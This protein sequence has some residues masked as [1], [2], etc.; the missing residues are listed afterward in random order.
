M[1]INKVGTASFLFLL[2]ICCCVALAPTDGTEGYDAETVEETVHSISGVITGAPEDAFLITV[3]DKNDFKT[4]KKTGSGPFEIKIN[5]AGTY[6]I[7]IYRLGDNIPFFKKVDLNSSNDVALGNVTIPQESNWETPNYGTSLEQSNIKSVYGAFITSSGA[8]KELSYI[9][10]E[11]NHLA[12]LIHLGSSSGT[13][14]VKQNFYNGGR[15]TSDLTLEPVI[16][17]ND[18]SE[19]YVSH[20]GPSPDELRPFYTYSRLKFSLTIDHIVC[21]EDKTFSK[22]KFKTTDRNPRA[23]PLSAMTFNDAVSSIGGESFKESAISNLE[24]KGG[25]FGNIG[26]E[27]FAGS[28]TSSIDIKMPSGGKIGNKAFEGCLK[29]KT[30]SIHTDSTAGIE[31]GSDIFENCAAMRASSADFADAALQKISLK[32]ILMVASSS[33]GSG[34]LNSKEIEILYTDDFSAQKI[35]GT[36]DGL[37]FSWS[38]GST[39]SVLIEKELKPSFTEGYQTY[40]SD[41]FSYRLTSGMI[42]GQPVHYAQVTSIGNITAGRNSIEIPATIQKDG[43]A[44]TI[45]EIGTGAKGA[46]IVEGITFDRESGSYSI[47]VQYTLKIN[48]DVAINSWAFTRYEEMQT[49][50]GQ[51]PYFSHSGLIELQMNGNITKIGDYAFAYSEVVSLDLSNTQTIGEHAFQYSKVSSVDLTSASKIGE[52]AFGNSALG[53]ELNLPDG[54][55]IGYKAFEFTKITKV[56]IPNNVKMGVAVFNNCAEL[57][58]YESQKTDIPASTFFSCSALKQV[59]YIDNLVI[60][61]QAFANS[62]IET[63][64]LSRI[65]SISAGAF[66]N[67]K[68]TNLDVPAE[69]TWVGDGQFANCRLLTNVQFNGT[70]VPAYCF[71]SCVQLSTFTCSSRSLMIGN[72]SFK[73]TGLQSFDFSKVAKIGSGA[74]QGTKLNEVSLGPSVIMDVGS[75]GQFKDCID[76]VKAEIQ[77][78]QVPSDCFKDCIKISDLTLNGAESIGSGAFEGCTSLKTINL[79]GVS[80]IGNQAFKNSQLESISFSDERIEIGIEAFMSTK[81]KNLIIPTSVIFSS[82]AHG[83]FADC[84]DLQSVTFTGT[85]ETINGTLFRN[86]TSL[87]AVEFPTGLKTIGAGAFYG[88][89]SLNIME[90]E[91]DLS[92]DDVMGWGWDAFQGTSS[93]VQEKIEETDGYYEYLPLKLKQDGVTK[94]FKFLI[95]VE[96]ASGVLDKGNYRQKLPSDLAGIYDEVITSGLTAVSIEDNQKYET[97][98]GCLFQKTISGR[99]LLRVPIYTEFYEIPYDISEIGKSVFRGC[100][101]QEISIPNNVKSIRDEAFINNAELRSVRLNEGLE[102]I[103]E[104][105]F[106]GCG[107]EEISIPSSVRT[108]G[109]NAFSNCNNLASI[110]IPTDT[111]LTVIGESAFNGSIIESIFLPNVQIGTY[112]FSTSTLKNVY[113]AAGFTSNPG[114]IFDKSTIIGFYLPVGTESST[115]DFS[116]FGGCEQG[117]FADYYVVMNNSI[118]SYNKHFIIGDYGLYFITTVGDLD[119]AGEMK[120]RTFTFSISAKGG[121]SYHDLELIRDGDILKETNG[122]FT[123]NV[124]SDMFVTVNERSVNQYYELSFD[125][126]GGSAT[127][128]IRIGSGRT[129]LDGQYPVPVKDSMEFAGWFITDSVEF[130]EDTPV[131]ES[132]RLIAHW[133]QSTPMVRFH[134]DLGTILASIDDNDLLTETRVA[135]GSTVTFRYSDTD[136]SEFIGWQ[137]SSGGREWTDSNKILIVSDVNNDLSVSV[138]ERYHSNSNSVTPIITTNTPLVNEDLSILWQTP[139]VIDTSTMQWTG[140]SSVPLIVDGHIYVRASD[141]LYMIEADT[142]FVIKSV[143]SVSVRQYYHYTGYAHGL[144][145]D[146]ATGKVYD[147]NLNDYKTLDGTVSVVF[148]DETSTYVYGNK[149]LTKYDATLGTKQWSKELNHPIFGQFGTTSSVVFKDGYLYYIYASSASEERGICAVDCNNGDEISY[150]KLDRISGFYLDDGWM[151][152][153]DDTLYM[154]CYTVGLFGAKVA[155]GTEGYIVA[156]PLEGGSFGTPTYTESG[157]AANSEFVVYNGRGYV[158]AGHS[159]IVYD[160]DGANLKRAYSVSTSYT[161]GGIVVDTAYATPENGNK[162]LIYIIP[163]SPRSGLYVVEDS[164]GQTKG[165]VVNKSVGTPQYNSQAIRTTQD[166]KLVWYTDSGNVFCVGTSRLNDYYFFIEGPTESGWYHANGLTAADALESLGSDVI[167]LGDYKDI[168]TVGGKSGTDWKIWCL[169]PNELPTG[170]S[171]YNWTLLNNLFDAANDKIHYYV[172]SKSLPADGTKYSYID[173]SVISTYE[174]SKNIGDRKVIGNKMTLGDAGDT[175]T[176]RFFDGESEIEDSALIGTKGSATEGSF[177]RIYRSGWSG[178]WEDVSGQ[179][180]EFPSTFPDE[181]V[182]YRILWVQNSYTMTVSCDEIGA[183]SYFTIETERKSGDKDVIEAHVILIAGYKSGK[184]VNVFSDELTL[185]SIGDSKTRIGVSTEDLTSVHAYL[186][187]GTPFGAFESYGECSYPIIAG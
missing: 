105:A 155:S 50:A 117:T 59:Y 6:Y 76:L 139:F 61:E 53:G 115:Y 96:G 161:H 79:S 30:I 183:M 9:L 151:T 33:F 27:A 94:S 34:V 71:E 140:H 31:I 11:N 13:S 163:Y 103:G 180:V 172:I 16:T 138:K 21:I 54:C 93:T 132:M 123:L 119:I 92:I 40:E 52:W 125:S 90:K 10:D 111:T 39:S 184:F 145:V 1:H 173:G 74:F 46:C 20:I 86:C 128:T 107:I 62:G 51:A 91:L 14:T 102:S 29:L 36:P 83:V 100:P 131:N 121:Y 88:C 2:C 41:G 112:A 108:I 77:C 156:I 98:D 28:T 120:D 97:V 170:P 45:T 158:N 63:L 166:G 57:T 38:N 75:N 73:G 149:I 129:M 168:I 69:I 142:G 134:A 153:Y 147:C 181:D 122:K 67:T 32:N 187:S 154:T 157:N 106:Y 162:V 17:L 24:F 178:H 141:K 109:K 55:D 126:A 56:I 44:Y 152:C 23:F 87:T 37:L 43:V 164:A 85:R 99:I 101:I 48:S 143:E 186:I 26:N 135:K 144:I 169:K 5:A 167:T 82:G 49:A 60:G 70:N 137:I 95:Y 146:Y 12:K 175:V 89:T 78:K 42:R 3:F 84:I 182:I 35:Q 130:T 72:N 127:K 65:K 68:L 179:M 66:E 171:D 176:I 159:L 113:L 114:S 4:E 25:I 174:F 8:K 15:P 185:G 118:I 148:Y 104:F 18:G 160:V 133:I 7:T 80:K 150:L 124:D 116:A 22:D 19:Y 64:N 58:S 47:P 81:I 110:T 165:I 136:C 177:P